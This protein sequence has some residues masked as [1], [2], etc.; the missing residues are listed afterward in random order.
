MLGSFR[1]LG[2]K[3]VN[4]QIIEEKTNV[5]VARCVSCEQLLSLVQ[6]SLPA[7]EAQPIEAHLSRCEKCQEL[8]DQLHQVA[9]AT[10]RRE[11]L[12]PPVW[13]TRSV[14]KLFAWHSSSLSAN[15]TEPAPA[16]LLVDSWADERLLG[17]RG[18]NAMSRQML[19][20]AGRYDIDLSFDSY[21]GRQGVAII[22]QSL[23]VVTDGGRLAGAPVRLLQGTQVVFDTRMNEWGEFVM[24]DVPEGCYTL[25]LQLG[26]HRIDIVA[27]DVVRQ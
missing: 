3:V 10:N 4:A 14:Q 20:R 26:K 12:V 15:E 11:L 2:A 17:F 23:P 13:L 24:D 16:L 22:G 7:E 27:L 5:D 1:L 8:F 18:A 19:Y 9:A 21:E 6:D 25:S